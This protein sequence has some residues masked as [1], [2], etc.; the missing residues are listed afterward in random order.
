M[1]FLKRILGIQVAYPDEVPKSM[2]NYI[3]A[4]YKIQK[5]ML[6]GKEAL[7]VYTKE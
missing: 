6:N 2:P 5:V 3:D 4:R 1:E 7:F